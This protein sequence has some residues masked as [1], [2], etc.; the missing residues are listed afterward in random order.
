VNL[1]RDYATRIVGAEALQDADRKP[2][3]CWH[4]DM[5]AVTPDAIYNRIEYWVERDTYRSVKG[6][7]YADSGRLLKVAYYHRYEEQLGAARPTRVV[8][9]D[10]VNSNLV[11]TI[12][13]SEYRYQD[14]PEAWFQRDFLPRMRPE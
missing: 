12:D 7:F 14:I 3:A 10:A 9:I 11:T 13:Y 4:L 8:L 1:A 2:R 5:K 6:K